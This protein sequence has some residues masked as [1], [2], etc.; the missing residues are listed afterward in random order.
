M[1]TT[2]GI[3]M[4]TPYLENPPVVEAWVYVRFRPKEDAKQWDPRVAE[5]FFKKS[6]GDRY[7]PKDIVARVAWDPTRNA[8]T[9]ELSP[10]KPI[11]QR[12]RAATVDEDR[13]VQAGRNVLVYNMLRKSQEWPGFEALKSEALDA[14]EKYVDF[15]SPEGI[16]ALS[17]NY[18]D[19]VEYPAVD[20]GGMLLSHYLRIYPE[21]P[22]EVFG[23]LC[24][25]ALEVGLPELSKHGIMRIKIKSEPRTEEDQTTAVKARMARF[26]V[27]WELTTKQSLEDRQELDKWLTGAHEDMSQAFKSAFTPA[28]WD[29]FGPK[30]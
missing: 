16:Q 29:I 28:G 9:G 18:R 8:S 21:V 27:D 12:A 2:Q 7:Q 1:D 11:F 22:H 30:E 6:F 25:F 15:T 24:N 3:Q 4:A 13:F 26:R 19:I 5:E 20:D 14:L 10:P 23:P 17:L